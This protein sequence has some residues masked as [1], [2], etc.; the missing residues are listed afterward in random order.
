[1]TLRNAVALC[2]IAYGITAGDHP[3]AVPR[4]TAFGGEYALVGIIQ[5]YRFQQLHGR[6]M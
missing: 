5:T 3:F 6:L 4:C 1:V 2:E